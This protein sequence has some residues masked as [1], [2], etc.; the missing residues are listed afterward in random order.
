MGIDVGEW[1]FLFNQMFKY[2]NEYDVFQ[3]ISEIARVKGVSI[4]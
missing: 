3:Y 1:L 4:T 2:L